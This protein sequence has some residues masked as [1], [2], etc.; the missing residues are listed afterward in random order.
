MIRLTLLLATAA[1]LLP[2]ADYKLKASPENIVWGYYSASARP[3]LTIKSGDVVEIQN[4]WGNPDRMV[5]SGVR[6]E[7]IEPELREIY[8]RIPREARGPGSHTLTGP[9]AIEGAMPGDVLEVRIREIRMNVPYAWNS[10]GKT[11]GFL[12]G[13][14]DSK[15]KIIPLDRVKL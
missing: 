8:Q 9:V 10:F 7:Q 5:A 2:A 1:V 3:A 6:P 11:S 14:F 4:V 13:E 12:P 15:M